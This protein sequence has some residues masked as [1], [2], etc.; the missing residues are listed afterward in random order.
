MKK[1]RF[2]TTIEA[3][4]EKVWRVL[5]DDSTYGA[6]TEPSSPG[7]RAITDWQEGSKVVF[8]ASEE[9][10]MYSVIE[11]KIP[12][13]FMSFRHLGE[14]KDGREQLW[15]AQHQD[16]SETLENY[17]LT[18]SDGATTLLVEMDIPEEH[19]PYF[20]EAFPQALAKVKELAEQ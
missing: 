14:I 8:T 5:W 18:E 9:G 7:S 3:P 15:D 2:S 12:N 16:W 19:Q 11:K 6:W 20:A 10:G 4:K 1:T 13:E 17:T